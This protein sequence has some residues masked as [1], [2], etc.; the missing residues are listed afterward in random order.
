MPRATGA[1]YSRHARRLDLDPELDPE[2][3]PG[4][5]LDLDHDLDHHAV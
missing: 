1:L 4:P 3:D 5:D 2:L